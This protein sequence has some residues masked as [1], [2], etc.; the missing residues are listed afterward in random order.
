VR[1]AAVVLLLTCAYFI[2]QLNFETAS[3]NFGVQLFFFFYNDSYFHTILV[4]T[5]LVG[6]IGT[7][8]LRHLLL[9]PWVTRGGSGAQSFTIKRLLLQTTTALIAVAPTFVLGAAAFTSLT[10]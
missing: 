2:I 5:S 8:R 4:T 10:P 6:L 3:H 1:S 7:L 9:S